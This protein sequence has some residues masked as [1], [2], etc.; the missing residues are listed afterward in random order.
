MGFRV[1][2]ALLNIEPLPDDEDLVS[3][4]VVRRENGGMCAMTL[5]R[6]SHDSR[7]QFP[8]PDAVINGRKYWKRRTLRRHRARIGHGRPAIAPRAAMHPS[9]KG[10]E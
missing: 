2:S 10:P 7:M 9:S 3:S 6:W 1:M 4:A 8:P 5:W